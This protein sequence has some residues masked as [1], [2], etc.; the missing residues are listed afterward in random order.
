MWLALKRH[1]VDLPLG[2]KEERN[3]RSKK[4]TPVDEARESKVVGR[5]MVHYALFVYVAKQ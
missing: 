5:R 3:R 4:Y 2:W 1:L